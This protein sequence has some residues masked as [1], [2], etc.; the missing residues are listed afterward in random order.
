MT[1]R[2][3]AH[4]PPPGGPDPTGSTAPRTRGDRRHAVRE[5]LTLQMMR[6][7]QTVWMMEMMKTMTMRMR[8]MTRMMTIIYQLILI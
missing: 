7:M 4:R 5:A 3:A 1:A 8:T 6:M 2:S